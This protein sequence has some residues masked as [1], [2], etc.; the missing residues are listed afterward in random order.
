MKG[1]PGPAR[2]VRTGGLAL[3]ATTRPDAA[4]RSRKSIPRDTRSPV[5][6]LADACLRRGLDTYRHARAAIADIRREGES[7]GGV[8]DTENAGGDRSGSPDRQE[9][10]SRGAPGCVRDRANVDSRA[11]SDCRIQSRW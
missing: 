4:R 10:H 1:L 5:P 3:R 7:R 2:A 6:A 8:L 9:F 11:P